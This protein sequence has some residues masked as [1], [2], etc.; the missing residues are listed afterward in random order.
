MK[1]PVLIIATGL[2]GLS[3]HAFS[4]NK[5]RLPDPLENL[6]P[7]EIKRLHTQAVDFFRA[8]QPAV[9][10]A[11]KST[12]SIH[13]SRQRVAFGTVVTHPDKKQPV[14]LTKWSEVNKQPSRL[15]VTTPMG[16]RYPAQVVGIYPDHDLALLTIKSPDAKLVPLD[17]TASSTPE[18]GS[19]ITLA[20]PD[21]HVQ[22]LGV[23]SVHARSLRE[24]DKAYLGVLMDFSP[25]HHQGVPL[26]EVMPN[27]AAARA[28][29]REGDVILSLDKKP[30]TGAMEMRNT[31]QRLPPGSKMIVR[32]RRGHADKQTTVHLGSRSENT[33]IRAFPR[34]RMQQM[35]QM[36]TVPSRIRTNFPNVIQSDIAIQGDST[37]NNPHDNQTND[38]GGPVTDLNGNIVGIAIARGS[39]IKTY[40]IPTSTLQNLLTTHPEPVSR[41][42][43]HGNAR[44]K[45]SQ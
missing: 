22:G 20:R 12:V 6:R 2:L 41:H 36:G 14:I 32:Y 15:R 4:Q 26:K 10:T 37:P 21:G 25:T 34:K 30:I 27:S 17:L 29:L 35:E 40:I 13:S 23:V 7:S 9:A 18:L 33:Q 24:G 19:F 5:L 38:C 1:R 11:S 43:P 31:L 28:G 16:K 44:R 45:T 8:A 3:I 39:R 42:L